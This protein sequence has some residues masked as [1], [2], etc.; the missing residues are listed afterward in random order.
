MIG[1]RAKTAD[2]K[3]ALSA[4]LGVALSLGVL[5]HA[6]ADERDPYVDDVVLRAQGLELAQRKQWRRLGYWR[7]SVLGG[8][9][10]EVD[11]RAFFLAEDGK[12]NPEAELEAT[13]RGFF[14]PAT[15]DAHPR[16]VFPA[17]FRWLVR[18]LGIDPARVPQKACPKHDAF[19]ANLQAQSATVVFS[20][21]YL[22]NAASA[23]G[24]TFLRINRRPQP[25]ASSAER[26][27]LLDTGVNY[28]A[29]VNTSNALLYAF[30]GLAGMFDG[31]FTAL[32]YFY[33]VREYNDYESRDLWE[34][35]LEL[36]PES[37]AMLLDHIW[38]L[39]STHFDYWYLSENCSYHILTTIEAADPSLELLS[40]LHWPVL[41]VDTIKAIARSPG[42]IRTIDFRPSARTQLAARTE[43]M[44]GAQRKWVAE[45]AAAPN[46][47]LPASVS[48]R[49]SIRILDAAADFIDIRHA[50]ELVHTGKDTEGARLKQAL[51]AR[52]AKIAVAS[53]P[54][55]VAPPWTK[56]PHR[57][58]DSRRI[59]FGGG[60]A[61]ERG[62]FT[63]LR[64][65]L[66]MHD[67]ADASWGYPE[68]TR[69]EFLTTTLRFWVP[70]G[71]LALED[72]YLVRVASLSPLTRFNT[73][74]SWRLDAG[75]RRVFDDGC[76]HC[77]TT[78]AEL[79]GGLTLGLGGDRLLFYVMSD[80]VAGYGLRVDGVRDT[81][82]RLGIGPSAGLRLR[83]APGLIALVTGAWHWL[84]DQPSLAEWSAE[85]TARF[86][87]SEHMA[88]DL[89]ATR[90]N[91]DLEAQ[92]SW[93][94]Y[95]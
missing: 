35:E 21:Y 41:P 47:P 59:S 68:T 23:F 67:L 29:V 94:L 46:T 19:I 3:L 32:P 45:L 24:H 7:D 43:S 88:F 56:L 63:S 89:G 22:N 80:M 69:L 9:S 17:R 76:D 49:D 64:L 78:H 37:L 18:E 54:L 87:V 44:T 81:A 4:L 95:F 1:G 52:R 33:K 25:G 84:P 66:A 36:A 13:L 60:D 20:S 51:L 27:A 39:G 48:P 62:A 74:L 85:A 93:L 90:N 28:A 86:T 5:A 11:G 26:Q 31:T 12:T 50:K 38:E 72:F 70:D 34:Y 82:M 77:L 73:K 16:C 14:R 2:A 55:A 30:Q 10:S 53:E 6:R 15:G 65:R 75:A 40:Q 58:H 83:F 91:R 42:L 79:A 92:A 61:G 8:A 57:G 71:R